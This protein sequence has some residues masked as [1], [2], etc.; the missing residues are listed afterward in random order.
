MNDFNLNKT[1]K[2][3]LDF[4]KMKVDTYKNKEIKSAT[5]AIQSED[6]KFLKIEF[7]VIFQILLNLEKHK[8]IKNLTITDLDGGTYIEDKWYPW[9][10]LDDIYFPGLCQFKVGNEFYKLYN[11]FIK[12]K[13]DDTNHKKSMIEKNSN[14]NFLNGYL[15]TNNTE[16]NFNKKPIQKDL[17]NTIFKDPKKNWSND[18][19]FEDWGETEF[20]NKTKKFYTAGDA[21]NKIIKD[22]TEID[23]FLELSTKYIKI[24]EEYI[25]LVR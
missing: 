21:I 11:N 15:T 4:I 18:E 16:I 17:L 3:I 13:L 1:T 9:R 25:K 8:I 10:E 19:I 20:Q 23:N 14:I 7:S 24:N 5:F 6:I 22:K 12:N 2:S